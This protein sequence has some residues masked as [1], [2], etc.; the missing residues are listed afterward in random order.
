MN[1]RRQTVWRWWRVDAVGL[2]VCAAMTLVVYLAGV[3]P[4]MLEQQQ[5]AAK[6]AELIEASKQV[7]QMESAAGQQQARL[8]DMRRRLDG[9]RIHLEPASQLNHR[10]AG[11]NDL[12]AEAGLAV[13]QLQPQ[14]MITNEHV[15][16][17]PIE[18][19]GAGGYP[20]CMTFLQLVHARFADMGVAGL[21]LTAAG[22]GRFR[23]S[24]MWYTAPA[25]SDP[26]Q[27]GS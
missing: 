8:V 24:L 14:A 19:H 17:I 4:L 13:E 5:R 1:D 21:D 26:S 22:E 7:A 10:L 25:P 20:A 11:L 16:V 15:Q 27:S 18:V 12:A 9:S 2:G 3:R 6:Q 23:M